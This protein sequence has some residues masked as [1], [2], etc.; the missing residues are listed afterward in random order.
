M[1]KKTNTNTTPAAVVSSEVPQPKKIVR[2]QPKR[3]PKKATSVSNV[4]Q[5]TTTVQKVTPNEGTS[6]PVAT[7]RRKVPAVQKEIPSVQEVTTKPNEQISPNTSAPQK[8]PNHRNKNVKPKPTP[9]VEMVT[10]SVEAVVEKVNMPTMVN[11]QQ[12][13][14]QTAHSPK[15]PQ[16]RNNRNNQRRHQKQNTPQV[17]S[18]ETNEIPSENVPPVVATIENNNQTV[19]VASNTTE[20]VVVRNKKNKKKKKPKNKAIETSLEV[21]IPL[22]QPVKAEIPTAKAQPPIQKAPQQKQ[23]KKQEP[24]VKEVKKVKPKLPLNEKSKRLFSYLTPLAK[25]FIKKVFTSLISVIPSIEN[26]S[27]I[28]CVSGGKDSV[29]LLDALWYIS[30]M[31]PLKI[32]VAH[33]NHNLRGEE[34]EKDEQFV[35]GLGKK[36]TV[37]TYCTSV[38]VSAYSKKYKQSIELAARN[39]RYRFFERLAKEQSI[40][41]ILTAH[42]KDDTVETLLFNLVRGTGMRGITGIPRK[43]E[44]DDKI[45][46]FRPILPISREEISA[47]AEERQLEWREDS[48]NTNLS[49]TRNKI[50]HKLLPLLKE[51]F[52]PSVL[53]TLYRFVEFAKGAES[54]VSKS[55]ESYLPHIVS[56]KSNSSL[57]IHLESFKALSL[58]LKGELLLRSIQNHFEIS[59][60]LLHIEGVVQLIDKET[61]ARYTINEQLHVVKERNELIIT[62]SH[63]FKETAQFIKKTGTYHFGEWTL[64][65]E[66]VA[67]QSVEFNPDPLVEYIDE[68]CLPSLLILRHWQHGDKFS[69]IGMH[70]LEQNVSDYLTNSKIPHLE[71]ERTA[72]LASTSRIFWVCGMRLSENCKVTEDTTNVLKA[73]YI[74]R[75]EKK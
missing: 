46:V 27:L 36:Y 49:F 54:I 59:L 48:S 33:C 4:E 21:T 8:K 69:P 64:V 1:P 14:E 2:S 74:L 30:G 23:S 37:S 63:R 19:D 22:E 73:T 65:L 61:G 47:Y 56:K 57:S 18:N 51:E 6:K 26:E 25:D 45:T 7:N 3:T 13:Q 43:R 38:N 44:L 55:V 28:V 50:R 53:D 62:N 72:V 29:V 20:Q 42:T 10:K 35:R 15:R 40:S 58:F 5:T 17:V 41:S 60:S 34:S 67:R 39:L 31:V 24:V 66:K 12:P 11:E 71:R 32:V 16:H 75:S 9:A 70:G 68:D 52:N